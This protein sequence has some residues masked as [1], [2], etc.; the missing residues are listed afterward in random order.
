MSEVA[1]MGTMLLDGQNKG[2]LL[3]VGCGSGR[4]LSRMRKAGW[5][6]QGVEL[7]PV[8]AELAREQF[9][10]PVFAGTLPEA[11]FPEGSFD[12]VVLSHVIEHVYDPV[13]L[14]KECRRVLKPGGRLTIVTPNV[15]SRGHQAFREHWSELDPPRHLNLFSI[16]T[17]R[18]CG[19]HAGLQIE[20]LRTS[21]RR[22]WWVWEASRALK[23]K[24]TFSNRDL[25]WLVSLRGLASQVR[26]GL[27][28]RVR[29]EAG[30]ELL[31]LASSGPPRS[32]DR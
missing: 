20:V 4:F 11:N 31:L 25:T 18:A 16:D 3:E 32:G 14:L 12:A 22:A 8:A 5:E 19:E 24:G 30:E 17:M 1:K 13:G 21:E 26:E 29:A 2:K 10:L 6:V 7:D 23:R 9:A 15:R 28:R 27:A